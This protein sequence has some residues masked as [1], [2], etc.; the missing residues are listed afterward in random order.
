MNNYIP[1]IIMQKE[2]EQFTFNHSIADNKC[3]NGKAYSI[4]LRENLLDEVDKNGSTTFEFHEAIATALNL[5]I[6]FL[7]EI[8]QH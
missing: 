4:D 7:P 5:F 8:E 3:M 1:R 6:L 2:L